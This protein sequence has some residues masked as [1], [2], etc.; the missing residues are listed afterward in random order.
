[1]LKTLGDFYENGVVVF[2]VVGLEF[3]F[4]LCV[5]ERKIWFQTHAMENLPYAFSKPF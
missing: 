5:R 1:M 2:Y 4:F 3:V